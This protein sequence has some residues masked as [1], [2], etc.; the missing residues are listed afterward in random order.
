MDVDKVA[1]YQPNAQVSNANTKNNVADKNMFLKI[2]SA[3]LAHPDPLNTKDSTE[4]ISQL[5]QFS[6]L[7]QAQNLNISME[8]LLQS[9]QI[10]EGSTL[11]GRKAE[12]N[13]GNGKYVGDTVRCVRVA[14]G[15]VYLECDNGNYKIDQVAGVGDV[16]ND[17]KGGQSPEKSKTI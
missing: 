3:E 4:Y 14:E 13:V 12:F 6:S 9:Q 1:S 15:D 16:E 10:D 8:K 5:A 11:I 17:S 2:L 7:E